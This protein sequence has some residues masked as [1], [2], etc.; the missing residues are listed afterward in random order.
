MENKKIIL[1]I[2]NLDK[3]YY[4]K[5]KKNIIFDNFSLNVYENE[6]LGIL[7]KNGCG[8]TTL[9]NM[10]I[11]KTKYQK[12]VID[13]DE[14]VTDKIKNVGYIPQEFKFP[15]VFTIKDI[16]KIIKFDLKKNG[17]NDPDFFDYVYKCF[18]IDSM[19]NK[20]YSKLS[21]GEKQKINLVSILLYKPKFLIL[22]EFTSNIDIQTSIKIKEIFKSI[23]STLIIISHNAKEISELCNRL[24]FIN[25]GK[26]FK[27]INNKISETIIKKTFEEMG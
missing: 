5:N 21:G 7:G 15:V 25:K 23:N 2:K 20:K 12:G 16:L 17:I 9:V 18:E 14:S 3:S 4:V 10:I 27:E 26:I 13:F 19:L 6:R 1:S 22:D 24:V 11:G 8:K